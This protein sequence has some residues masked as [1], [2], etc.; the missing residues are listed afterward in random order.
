MREFLTDIKILCDRSRAEIERGQL[1]DAHVDRVI[2]VL[3]EALATELVC[4][5]RYKRHYFTAECLNA[6][7]VADGFL[8]HAV[9][10]AD[11]ADLIA[12]RIVQLGGEPDF[13]PETRTGK[14]HAEV[15]SA[16]ELE[17]MIREDMVAERVVIDA[18]ALIIAW[19]GEMDPTSKMMCEQIR[20]MKEEHA[21][22]MRDLLT[23]VS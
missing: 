22:Q 1:T 4:V 23:A 15:H 17:A 5:L 14:F 13:H 21:D 2:R 9:E 20:A 6:Q 16:S 8:Q 10:E 18:Y 11:H 3:N 7:S 12:A 19:L